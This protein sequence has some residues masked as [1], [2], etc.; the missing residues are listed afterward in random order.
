MSHHNQ[1][2]VVLD[3]LNRTAD[4]FLRVFTDIFNLFCKH[5]FNC[6]PLGK[7]SV[8]ECMQN[9]FEIMPVHVTFSKIWHCLQCT[10]PLKNTI[11]FAVYCFWKILPSRIFCKKLHFWSQISQVK[12]ARVCCLDYNICWK[13]GFLHLFS[14]HMTGYISWLAIL[15]FFINISMINPIPAPSL[16]CLTTTTSVPF[17]FIYLISTHI[18]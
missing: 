7:I 6:A 10:P 18:S 4:I 9:W 11:P 1:S 14:N 16:D 15:V 2:W 3:L 5:I 13:W 17:S 8:L 12:R